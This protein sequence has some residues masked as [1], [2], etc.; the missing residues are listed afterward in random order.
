MKS[1]AIG[2]LGPSNAT[3]D[4]RGLRSLQAGCSVGKPPEPNR[5]RRPTPITWTGRGGA[6]VAVGRTSVADVLVR[7]E[8]SLRT[9][10]DWRWNLLDTIIVLASLWDVGLEPWAVGSFRFVLRNQ[11]KV[12]SRK[13]QSQVTEAQDMG[14]HVTCV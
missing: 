9:N 2:I 12:R 7:A 4:R 11:R 14:G 13:A 6:N 8:R 1:R 10:E 3:L 5:R